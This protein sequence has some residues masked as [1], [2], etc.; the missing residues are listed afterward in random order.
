MKF[1]V[2][3]ANGFVGRHL[4]SHLASQGHGV[5][6]VVRGGKAASLPPSAGVEVRE[7]DILD[8]AQ[9]ERALAGTEGVFHLAALFNRSESSWSDFRDVNVQ[10]T[11]NVVTSARSCGLRR[12]V[13]CST[14]GVATEAHA[15]PYDENTPYSPQPDDSYEVTKSEGEQAAIATARE[16][17]VGY[18]V[19]RPTQIYGPGDRAKLKLYWLVR[20][21]WVLEPGATLKHPIYVDDL[22][23]GFELAMTREAAEGE[24]FL[25]G[26]PEPV[27]L[28]EMIGMIAD[29]LGVN[30]PRR[31]PRGPA[32]IACTVAERL[33][34]LLGV[35]S[36]VHRG[37]MDFFSRSIAVS[38]KKARDVLGFEASTPLREGIERTTAWYRS[39]GQLL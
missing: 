26:N 19:I 23:A 15:P 3:G 10:G 24:I 20:K 30:Y 2:T 8:R 28:A 6:A 14:V 22:C 25:M 11:V 5:V 29:A 34:K 31:L 13:H 9:M 37:S 39:Q 32:L 4:V 35:R 38:T 27:R 17:G 36:P 21:G 12:V 7:A 1:A 33:S 16:L 18:C